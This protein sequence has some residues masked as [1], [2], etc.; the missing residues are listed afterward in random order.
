MSSC[1]LRSFLSFLPFLFFFA[2]SLG[3]SAMA[4]RTTWP[5]VDVQRA[6]WMGPSLPPDAA[7]G[8]LGVSGAGPSLA[9]GARGMVPT[10]RGRVFSKRWYSQV[11]SWRGGEGKPQVAEK[12]P[13]VETMWP[14]AGAIARRYP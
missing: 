14:R 1:C 8:G 4:S 6:G 3:I 2:E 7:P 11:R 9:G 5:I 10:F 13:K 12:M